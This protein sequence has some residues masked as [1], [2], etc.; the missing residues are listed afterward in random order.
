MLI[1]LGLLYLVLLL[2]LARR[3]TRS[4]NHLT[5]AVQQLQTQFA[6]LS[7]EVLTPTERTCVLS[8]PTPPTD[9]KPAELPNEPVPVEESPAKTSPVSGSAGFAASTS[10]SSKTAAAEQTAPSAE[11]PTKPPINESDPAHRVAQLL[12]KGQE[13]IQQGQY[14]A[15]VDC[16]N[17]ALA[18][19]PKHA[20]A[21][22]KKGKA[23]EQ[24][25]RFQEA[26]QSYEHALATDPT[27]TM[28]WLLK[29][30]ALNRLERHDEALKCYEIALQRRQ[31]TLAA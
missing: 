2:V 13:L 14:R 24:M 30:G 22:V 25:Q 9:A 15:A 31:K 18:L 26:L 27:L 19:D 5:N 17:E 7:T 12:E 10:E 11:S 29:A 3:Q 21:H 28:A 16:Y 23:L 8:P 1:G 20:E 6:L 4:I